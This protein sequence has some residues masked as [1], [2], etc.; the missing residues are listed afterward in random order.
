MPEFGD[1]GVARFY[2]KIPE[3]Q[4]AVSAWGRLGTYQGVAVGEIQLFFEAYAGLLGPE[5]IT[6]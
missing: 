3:G 2:D 5:R 1:W 4:V 6:C